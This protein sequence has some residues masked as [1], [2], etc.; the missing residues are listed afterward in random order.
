MISVLFLLL[1]PRFLFIVLRSFSFVIL[2]LVFLILDFIRGFFRVWEPPPANSDFFG[3]LIK[4]WSRDV[5][6]K[7]LENDAGYNVLVVLTEQKWRVCV[8]LLV[9]LLLP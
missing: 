7:F 3:L 4:D 5:R 9:C 2:R 6:F 8:V 1:L